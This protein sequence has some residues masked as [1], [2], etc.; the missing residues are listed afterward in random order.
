MEAAWVVAGPPG[1]GK[2]TAALELARLL[3]PAPAILDKDTVYGGMV[4]ALLRAHGRP[5][6]EREGPWYDEHIKQYEYAGLTATAR[7]IRAA[8]CPV[9]VVAPFTNQVRNRDPGGWD[10]FEEALG[11]PPV[12]LIWLSIDPE[13]LR[14]RLIA[15]GKHR[16][17]MKLLNYQ[18]FIARI[19]PEQEPD[20]PHVTVDNRDGARPMSDQL[21]EVVRLTA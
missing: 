10:G 4:A 11:G 7:E 15:R 8:G 18:A 5:Q 9:M 21:R 1:A 17:S 12:R 16:D 20:V 2:T 6:G 3:D 14:H 13:T 19:N